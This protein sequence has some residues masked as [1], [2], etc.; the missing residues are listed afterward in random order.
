MMASGRGIRAGKAYVE[1]NADDKGFAAGLARA[2][3]RLRHFA[4]TV[5][6]ASKAAGTAILSLNA[7]AV[8]ATLVFA[9][10]GSAL[11]DM[12][13]RTGASAEALSKLAY[14]AQMTGATSEDVEKGMRK[15]AQTTA[16]AAEGSDT[17]KDALAKFGLTAERLVGL[18]PD[19]QIAL[20]A[21]GRG[22]SGRRRCWTCWAGAGRR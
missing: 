7:P 22:R 1:I 12:S 18:S 15:L 2:G 3:A 5:A 19:K 10:M 11:A 13:A 8:A 16:D 6:S 21:D 9:K 14:A 20:L 17:A 4:S